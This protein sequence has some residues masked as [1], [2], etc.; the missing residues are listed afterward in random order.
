M[1]W[2]EPEQY[3]ALAL[4]PTMRGCRKRS[5]V[6]VNIRHISELIDAAVWLS[7]IDLPVRLIQIFAPTAHRVCLLPASVRLEFIVSEG[8]CPFMPFP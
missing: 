1:F 8:A 4:Q 5:D 6:A 3:L 2:R 7:A